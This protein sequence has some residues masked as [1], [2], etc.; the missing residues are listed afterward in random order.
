[1]NKLDTALERLSEKQLMI[2]LLK[3]VSLLNMRVNR[4]EKESLKN[5]AYPRHLLNSDK[6]FIEMLDDLAS[7]NWLLST[8]EFEMQIEDVMERIKKK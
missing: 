8:A 1:M 5:E 6:A 2:L 7:M 4:I 3:S